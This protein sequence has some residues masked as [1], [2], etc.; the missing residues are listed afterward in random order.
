MST[1]GEC[2]AIDPFSHVWYVMLLCI[3][4]VHCIRAVHSFLFPTVHC[5]ASQHTYVFKVHWV[6]FGCNLKMCVSSTV[7]R[8]AFYL[9]Q[10]IKNVFCNRGKSQLSATGKAR[11]ACHIRQRV[12]FIDPHPHHLAPFQLAVQ[13]NL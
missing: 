10:L 12:E 5:L 7:S 11:T 8:T 13:D 6:Q 2:Q 1:I 3:V 9:F 4:S